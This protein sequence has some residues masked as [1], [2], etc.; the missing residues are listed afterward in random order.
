MCTPCAK[1]RGKTCIAIRCVLRVCPAKFVRQGNYDDRC[2]ASGKFAFLSRKKSEQPPVPR[3]V[4]SC[5]LE[6][7]IRF[8]SCTNYTPV[9]YLRGASE[10]DILTSNL[11]AFPI[12][13]FLPLNATRRATIYFGRRS[14]NGGRRRR[15]L[16]YASLPYVYVWCVERRTYLN[17]D[18]RRRRSNEIPENPRSRGKK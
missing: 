13:I 11:L 18:T 17:D 12:P 8:A 15:R 7:I 4:Q 10:L 14:S 9:R 5:R 16:S 3:N 6:C 2:L 1:V